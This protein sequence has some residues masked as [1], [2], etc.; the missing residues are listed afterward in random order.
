MTNLPH[1]I[2]RIARIQAVVASYYRL[3]YEDMFSPVRDAYV[4]QP[5]QVAMYLVKEFVGSSTLE[6]GRRFRRDHSTV[7]SAL[8]A[9]EKRLVT[10][11][12]LPGEMDTLRRR[13]EREN[14]AAAIE[15]AL[16]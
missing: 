10:Q 7:I 11:S 5:R 14:I 13:I 6:I 9:V 16:P 15:M 1:Y 8:R 4:C 3:D 2:G 12:W